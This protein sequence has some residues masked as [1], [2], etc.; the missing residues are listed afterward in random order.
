[1]LR[2]SRRTIRLANF[3]SLEELIVDL[4][5]HRYRDEIPMA[6]P[7][8]Q[9]STLDFRLPSK[10]L[11]VPGR[12]LGRKRAR[13]AESRAVSRLPELALKEAESATV[14]KLLPSALH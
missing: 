9:H 4:L 6:P 11:I 5:L 8:A 12:N 2:M 1:M 14:C 10:I 13:G 3:A 7:I